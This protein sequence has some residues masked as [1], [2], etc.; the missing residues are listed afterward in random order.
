M[1]FGE[2][3][4]QPLMTLESILSGIYEPM[5]KA[6]EDMDWASCDSEQREEFK[7]GMSKFCHELTEAKS[8]LSQ[9]VKLRMP[10]K[11]YQMTTVDPEAYF[12]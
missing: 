10:D 8:S 3:A 7:T 11:K 1:I 2:L 9:G 5:V 4:P 6:M 12:S